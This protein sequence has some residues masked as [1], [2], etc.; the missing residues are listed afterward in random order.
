MLYTRIQIE[1]IREVD[2]LNHNYKHPFLMKF[3]N[4]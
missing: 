4:Q 3:E 2:A 1:I